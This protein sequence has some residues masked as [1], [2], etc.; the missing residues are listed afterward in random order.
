[1]LRNGDPLVPP[2]KI[3]VE[4]HSKDVDQQITAATYSVNSCG[5]ANVALDDADIVNKTSDTKNAEAVAVSAPTSRIADNKT[6]TD[7]IPPTREKDVIPPARD[8]V[9]RRDDAH[10]VSDERKTRTTAATK[11]LITKRRLTFEESLIAGT[12]ISTTSSPAVA[13]DAVKTSATMQSLP[14]VRSERI[15]NVEDTTQSVDKLSTDTKVTSVLNTSEKK[16]L[17]SNNSK[18]I[19]LEDEKSEATHHLSNAK[20]TADE[21]KMKPKASNTSVED[22]NHLTSSSHLIPVC[23]EP[24]SSLPVS[25]FAAV[26]CETK[27]DYKRDPSDSKSKCMKPD[28]TSRSVSKNEVSV[29]NNTIGAVAEELTIHSAKHSSSDRS[30]RHHHHHEDRHR[31][32]SSSSV[33]PHRMMGIHLDYELRQSRHSS[34]KYGSLMHVETHPNG[35]ASVVHAFE[36][37]LSS[38]SP[39]ELSE[40]VQEFFRVVFAEDPVGVPCYVMGIVHNSAAYL[41]DILEYFASASPDMVVKRNQLVKSSDVETTTIAEYFQ[42]VQSTYLA[43]TYRTGALE[44]FSIVGTKAEETGG[45]FPEFLDLLDQNEFLKYVSPWGKLSELEN[46]PRNES[47]D[48]PIV[49]ARP[50]EQVVPTADMPKS[51]MVKK[52]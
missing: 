27:Y 46:M 37:E 31:R 17:F 52:R 50:G 7:V 22:S 38:L 1:M 41:P 24:E 3:R 25:K 2:L 42:L 44:H 35:G 9:P 10:I 19:K 14:V 23:K 32:H 16:E 18:K 45:Y 12:C 47:N 13:T 21:G 5:L 34:S 51:P 39:R 40:F 4:H 6:E 49:W 11:P 15:H 30:T 43:G 20:N 33:K 36:D 26:R 8:A 28:V 29:S 48:G